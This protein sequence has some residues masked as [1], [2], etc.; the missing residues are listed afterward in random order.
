VDVEDIDMEV[1]ML[2]DVTNRLPVKT[3]STST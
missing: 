1:M 3:F 2:E